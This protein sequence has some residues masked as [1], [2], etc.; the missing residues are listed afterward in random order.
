MAARPRE[1]VLARRMLRRR[2][3]AG[4]SEVCVERWCFLVTRGG[5]GVSEFDLAIVGAVRCFGYEILLGVVRLTSRGA[6]R[7]GCTGSFGCAKIFQAR[8]DELICRSF[9]WAKKYR[10]GWWA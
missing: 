10:W 7:W 6:K 5:V 4:G 2:R 9:F 1:A 8:A 3:V